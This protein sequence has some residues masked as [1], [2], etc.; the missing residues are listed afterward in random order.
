MQIPAGQAN[1]APPVG[2]ALGQRGV[3]IMEFCKAFNAQTQSGKG[4]LTPVI[5][6]VFEDKSFTFI[7]KTP[8]ASTLLRMAAKV[9]KGSG[10]PNKD[11]VGVVTAKQV[12]EIA[13]QKMVDLNA[14]SVEMAVRMVEGTARSMG[15][16][17]Q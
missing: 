10:V 11:K 5:I 17:V 16:E 1:P 12:K 8:P 14:G 3:N 2:P 9:K 6:T 15:I 4:I 13:E 7:T